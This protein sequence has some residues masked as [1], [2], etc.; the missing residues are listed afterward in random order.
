MSE[1]VAFIT[2]KYYSDAGMDYV[3]NRLCEEF[4]VRG[5]NLVR[6]NAFYASFP[7]ERRKYDFAVFWDKDVKLARSLQSAG[8]RLFNSARTVEICDDKEKTFAAL[9]GT[10]EL[11]VTVIAPLVYDVSCGDDEDFLNYVERKIGY[12][13]VVKECVGSQG[14]QVFIA[15]N[16]AE[17]KGLNLRL[18]RVAHLYQ[19]FV[20]SGEPCGDVRVYT[21]GGK[22]VGA[23]KRKNTT[24]FRSNVALGGVIS[25]IEPT[26]VLILQAERIALALGMEYGC[27]DFMEENGRYM[28]I[29]ANSSPYMKNAESVGIPLASK[30]ADYIAE[31]IRELRR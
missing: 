3:Y 21:I 1:S 12:P 15:R 18:R 27:A 5:I 30:Y 13:A 6:D 9:S 31:V 4:A 7:P 11:P 22:V 10:V 2:N 24:D 28:F 20:H 17:L 26:R 19:R 23:V 29:E 16:R 14:R 8:V 25:R